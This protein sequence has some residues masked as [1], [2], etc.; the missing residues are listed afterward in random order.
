MSQEREY[1]IAFVDGSTGGFDVVETFTASCD[2]EANAYAETHYANQDWYVLDSSGRNING[3][4][5]L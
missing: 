5:A 3:G 1:R 4:S 2:D